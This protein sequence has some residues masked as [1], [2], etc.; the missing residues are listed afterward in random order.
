MADN[1]NFSQKLLTTGV[2]LG[3]V[4]ALAGGYMMYSSD[5]KPV[6]TSISSGGL[7]QKELTKQSDALLDYLKMDRSI[8]D[9]FAPE[10]AADDS[11][12]MT[13]FFFSPELWQIKTAQGE[14]VIDVLDPKATSIHADI[15]NIWFI[16]EGIGDALSRSDALTLDSDGDGF[17]TLEEYKN[18]TKPKDKSSYPLLIGKTELPKL[19]VK[20]VTKTNSYITTGSSLAYATEAPAEIKIGISASSNARP[21]KEITVKPGS[22]FGVTEGEPER[23]VVIGFVSRP[24]TAHGTETPEFTVHIRDT[25]QPREKS[26][27]YMRAGARRSNEAERPAEEQRGHHVFDTTATF[28]VTAGSALGTDDASFKADVGVPFTIPGH[29]ETQ[30]LIENIDDNGGVNIVPVIAPSADGQQDE[31]NKPTPINIPKPE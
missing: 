11:D 20:D 6:E 14:T 27:F 4:G 23:F 30:Y 31:N 3:L 13:Y 22:K 17:T 15:P 9:H 29:D 8:K 18:K 2:V 19:I 5:V 21:T 12:R 1:S 7:K 10:K 24:Y 26:Q 25:K 16:T 28:E